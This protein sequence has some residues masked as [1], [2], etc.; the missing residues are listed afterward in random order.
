MSAEF[1]AGYL[2]T[3]VHIPGKSGKCGGEFGG[4][5]GGE[6]GRGEGEGRSMLA[7]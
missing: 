3:R 2:L 6:G 1:G 5:K 7:S 4:L